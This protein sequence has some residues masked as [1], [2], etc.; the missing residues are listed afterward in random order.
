MELIK[1]KGVG[2][3]VKCKE[4]FCPKCNNRGRIK[5]VKECDRE[6]FE[7]NFDRLDATGVLEHYICYDEAIKDCEYDYF[8]CPD[9]EEGQLYK[10]Q[11]PVYEGI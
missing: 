7:R 4:E 8:Y 6:K 10:E 5:I 11:Y 9:C 1:N 3:N 2:K